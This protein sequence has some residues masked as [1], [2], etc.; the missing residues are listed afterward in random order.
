MVSL[1][2]M[3]SVAAT[4]PKS[5]SVA[6]VKLL[7]VTVTAVPP[8]WEPVVGLRPATVGGERSVLDSS[9]SIR[10]RHDF[11]RFTLNFR[12]SRIGLM[13]IAIVSNT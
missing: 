3:K 12:C 9:H 7:P 2:T 4:V 8:A 6:P 11:D 13:S 1:T 10:G 5:T